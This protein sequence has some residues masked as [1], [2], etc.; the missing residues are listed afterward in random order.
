MKFNNHTARDQN[1]RMLVASVL[2]EHINDHAV[3][4]VE[5]EVLRT[6]DRKGHR[7]ERDFCGPTTNYNGQP[8][9]LIR[10]EVELDERMFSDTDELVCAVIAAEQDA[11]NAE[12]SE[13]EAAATR[14]LQRVEELRKRRTVEVTNG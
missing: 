13:A 6:V 9:T 3:D 11:L 4:H 1:V 5:V 8:R 7:H 12:I 14:A 10:V 2:H